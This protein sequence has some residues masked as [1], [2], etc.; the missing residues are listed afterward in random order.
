MV[1]AVLWLLLIFLIVMGSFCL[2]NNGDLRGCF[3]LSILYYFPVTMFILFLAS[4]I[5]ALRI[6]KGN[7]MLFIL[8]LLYVIIVDIL[9]FF[10]IYDVGNF[11]FAGIIM[12]I[13]LISAISFKLIRN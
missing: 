3:F 11:G 7:I 8:A 13:Y 10:E 4:E 6:K 5:K 9:S 2:S 12:S 1:L